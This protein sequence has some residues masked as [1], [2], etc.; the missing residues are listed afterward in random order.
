MSRATPTKMT[1]LEQAK[2]RMQ[3][4]GALLDLT[5]EVKELAEVVHR[6]AE[7]MAEDSNRDRDPAES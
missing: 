6:I 5:R 3:I 1:E 7:K 2:W 4:S